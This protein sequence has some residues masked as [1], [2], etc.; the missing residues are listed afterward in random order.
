MVQLGRKKL[1]F[2]LPVWTDKQAREAFAA[3]E[4]DQISVISSFQFHFLK[5]MDRFSC[6]STV[7]SMCHLSPKARQVYFCPEPC[8]VTH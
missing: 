5:L 1:G 7:Q 8:F 3:A 4:V 6:V 2:K